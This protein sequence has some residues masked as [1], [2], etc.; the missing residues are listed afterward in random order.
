MGNER[1]L[2]VI[3]ILNFLPMLC[4]FGKKKK[5]KKKYSMWSGQQ[6]KVLGD[7]TRLK[8]RVREGVLYFIDQLTKGSIGME[9]GDMFERFRV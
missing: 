5:K 7:T 1:D 6:N 9:F 8:G 2:L 4:I 3:P